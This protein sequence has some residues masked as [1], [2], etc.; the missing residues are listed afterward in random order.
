MRNLTKEE[1]RDAYHNEEVTLNGVTFQM[2][3]ESEDMD[4]KFKI[5]TYIMG[6]DKGEHIMININLIRYG[7]EDYGYESSCQE[8][9]VYEVEKKEIVTVKWVTKK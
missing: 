9:E 3:D 1:H 2:V 8:L 4:D 7:H 5:L 6:N